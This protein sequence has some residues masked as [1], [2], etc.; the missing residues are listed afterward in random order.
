MA[1]C[2]ALDAGGTKTEIIVHD[3]FGHIYGRVIMP[4]IN[5][6]DMGV[7]EAQR[8]AVEAI[9]KGAALIPDG[10]PERVF[11]GIAS[12]YYY[13]EQFTDA[14]KKHF[15]GWKIRWED[16]GVG[17]I[18]S[19]IGQ[20]DGC[21]IVC[22]TGCSLFARIGDKIHHIG[23]WGY[24]IDTWGSGYV[25]GREAIRAAVRQSD[26]R[27]VKTALYELVSA[28]VGCPAENAVPL[29]YAGGRPY[30]ASFAKCVFAGC[31]QGDRESLRIFDEGARALAEMT[32]AAEPYF[33]GDFDVV[34]SGGILRNYPEY[35][36]A[37][38][39]YGSKRA[40][41]IA[42]D[43]PPVLGCALENAWA[44]GAVDDAA[45]RERFMT[46]YRK[47]TQ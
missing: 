41:M 32:N 15:S 26:G 18:S 16:D 2:I 7:E 27:G 29:L 36:K 20:K 45:F 39:G 24:L 11:A 8:R 23:G 33:D 42:A 25:L 30:I 1:Y 5:C 28:H 22:G 3:A 4:G 31:A 13:G 9:E 47:I 17:M 46:D 35:A 40:N 37:V 14:L 10:V 6:M 34:M 43:V 21:C 44:C 19:M 38:S 12:T